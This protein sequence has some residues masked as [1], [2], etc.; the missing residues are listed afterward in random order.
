VTI[1]PACWLVIDREQF[2]NV[3]Y[4]ANVI[5]WAEQH[6]KLFVASVGPGYNDSKIRPWNAGATR[7]RERGTRYARW[8][9]AALDS[10][11][12]AVSITSFNEYRPYPRFLCLTLSPRRPRHCESMICVCFAAVSTLLI[13]P[14]CRW[15]CKGGGRGRRL[16]RRWTI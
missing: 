14:V 10:R 4:V 13:I 8:W 1:R 5:R 16:S 11:A 9:G 2:A 3:C 12:V 15:L 6:G 7:D